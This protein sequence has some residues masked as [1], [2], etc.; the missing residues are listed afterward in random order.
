MKSG[1]NSKI[2]PS[3]CPWSFTSV[4]SAALWCHQGLSS[5]PHSVLSPS[6]HWQL[7]L[8][9]ARWIISAFWLHSLSQ[10][11]PEA[12]REQLSPLLLIFKNKETFPINDGENFHLF[13]TDQNCIAC[14]F[15]LFISKGD[16]IA[17][18][19]LDKPKCTFHPGAEEVANLPWRWSLNIW[20]N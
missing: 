11:H 16:G 12:E 4:Y 8:I 14:P 2:L 7:L 1:L 20:T 5:F 10:A 18:M 13:F 6:A 3:H 15:F 9:V 17:M 19:G